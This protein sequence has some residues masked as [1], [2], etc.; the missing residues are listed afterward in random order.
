VPGLRPDLLRVPGTDLLVTVGF[1]GE[2]ATL[3]ASADGALLEVVDTLTLPEVYRG[4]LGAVMP[5]TAR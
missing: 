3:R 1:D 2:V 4:R 5:C